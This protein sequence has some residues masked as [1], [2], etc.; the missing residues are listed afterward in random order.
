LQKN[1]GKKKKER[2]EYPLAINAEKTLRNEGAAQKSVIESRGRRGTG[3]GTSSAPTLEKGE[4][5]DRGEARHV[6]G[7]KNLQTQLL[8]EKPISSRGGGQKE[9]GGRR[10]ETAHG[11]ENK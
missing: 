9:K 7:K 8:L 10:G 6:V 2:G 1:G 3:R 5:E 4:G 11:K